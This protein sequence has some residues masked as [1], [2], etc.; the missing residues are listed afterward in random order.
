LLGVDDA[1]IEIDRAGRTL[2]S[3]RLIVCM[4]CLFSPDS[5][6]LGRILLVMK[7]VGVYY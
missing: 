5:G 6:L 4:G 3:G 7:N 2:I 1:V